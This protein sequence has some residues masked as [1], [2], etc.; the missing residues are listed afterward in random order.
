M[1]CIINYS[2]LLCFLPRWGGK[3]LDEQDLPNQVML[4][5][6]NLV[7]TISKMV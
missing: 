2:P 6:S 3:P 4:S 1:A 5:V 7:A